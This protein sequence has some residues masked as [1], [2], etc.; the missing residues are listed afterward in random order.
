MSYHEAKKFGIK[1]VVMGG[2]RLYCP[3]A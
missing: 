3:M 1:Q 2:Y